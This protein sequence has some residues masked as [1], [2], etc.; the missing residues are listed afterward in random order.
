M[1][2]ASEELLIKMREDRQAR[3][4]SATLDPYS[5]ILIFKTRRR[6]FLLVMLMAFI[7]TLML[8]AR[9]LDTSKPWWALA[10]PIGGIGLLITLFPITEIWLYGPWQ[11]RTRRYERHQAEK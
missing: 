4:K 8:I 5:K 1:T 3:E 6:Q 2:T 11:S 9:D 7:W 10:M